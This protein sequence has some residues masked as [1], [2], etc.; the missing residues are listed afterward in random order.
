MFDAL[1]QYGVVQLGTGCDSDGLTKG[2]CPS[3][4]PFSFFP[5]K[6]NKPVTGSGLFLFR[7]KSST[8]LQHF[9]PCAPLAVGAGPAFL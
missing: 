1:M 6:R 2:D 8:K 3:H 9:H 4:L 5:E 7:R